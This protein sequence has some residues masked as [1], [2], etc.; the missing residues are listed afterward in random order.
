MYFDR[1]HSICSWVVYGYLDI[2]KRKKQKIL[3]CEHIKMELKRYVHGR[4][5]GK[6]IIKNQNKTLLISVN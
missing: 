2:G 5:Q 1:V 4:L 3:W 6:Q